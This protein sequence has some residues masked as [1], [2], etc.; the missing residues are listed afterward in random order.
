M[1]TSR[2]L[3]RAASPCDQLFVLIVPLARPLLSSRASSFAYYLRA[4]PP[5][6]IAYHRT[7]LP[8]RARPLSGA[9]SAPSVLAPM[10]LAFLGAHS[11]TARRRI[12]APLC[13]NERVS[14]GAMRADTALF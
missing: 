9:S 14:C 11:A 1:H 7:S 13:T 4:A 8:V 10:Q 3:S 6:Q 5:E 12:P 2:V